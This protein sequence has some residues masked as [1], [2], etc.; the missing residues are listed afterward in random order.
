MS[1]VQGPAE[2]TMQCPQ[3]GYEMKVTESL[4]APLIAVVERKYQ[5]QMREQQAALAGRE[6]EVADRTAALEQQ[7]AEAE[8]RIAEQLR[9]RLE[10]EQIGRAH[11]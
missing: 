4:A 7:A 1:T 8:R 9:A 5:Q 10:I 6:R 3:C 2:Q 11:V